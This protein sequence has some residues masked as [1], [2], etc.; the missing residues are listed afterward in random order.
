MKAEYFREVEEAFL[1]LV[2]RGVSISE[3]DRFQIESWFAA[4]VPVAI[5]KQAMSD[6]KNSGHNQ[7]IRSLGYLSKAVDQAF[8][9][10]RERLVGK[11]HSETSASQ[12]VTDKPSNRWIKIAVE[13]LSSQ[14]EL[15]RDDQIGQAFL[16]RLFEFAHDSIP[17]G[18]ADDEEVF[19]SE[20][21]QSLSQMVQDEIEKE[22]HRRVETQD[23]LCENELNEAKGFIRRKIMRQRLNLP[24]MLGYIG[25]GWG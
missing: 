1:T 5:V 9:A 20:L 6:A 4:G 2:G 22:T 12:V 11:A 15:F 16:S 23:Y 8:S 18:L 21:W 3:K 19:F 7:K 24:D 14:M 10:F 13:R 25:K 17:G